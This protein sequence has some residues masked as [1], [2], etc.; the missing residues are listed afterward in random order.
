M[1]SKQIKQTAL[2][3]FP[4]RDKLNKKATGRYD[5]NMPRRKAYIQGATEALDDLWKPADSDDL[6]ESDREVIAL[7]GV[8]DPTAP[9]CYCSY[10]VVFAH[11]VREDA[12][13]PANIDDEPMTLHPI[14][15]GEA[16]WNSPDVLW[17][18]DLDI[19]KVE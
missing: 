2:K 14:G 10:R 11:R 3:L 6:P 8:K 16:R 17:W 19:P 4:I 7:E 18:L 5:P 15:Y 12:E 9:D 13:V 1:T